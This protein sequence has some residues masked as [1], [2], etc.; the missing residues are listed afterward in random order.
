MSANIVKDVI[1]GLAGHADLRRSSLSI[2]TDREDYSAGEKITA[3]IELSLK[4]PVKARHLEAVL[5][6]IET[7]KVKTVREMDHYD[8]RSEKELGIPRSTHLKTVVT[9]KTNTLFSDR[10]ST[11]LNSSHGYI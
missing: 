2:R 7:K 9:E 8:Y 3:E 10:K 1:S 4:R 5:S 11:R 6:C